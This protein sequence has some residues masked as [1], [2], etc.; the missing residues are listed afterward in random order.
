[1]RSIIHIPH[2]N[3]KEKSKYAGMISSP[4]NAFRNFRG[5]KERYCPHSLVVMASSSVYN[6]FSGNGYLLVLFGFTMVKMINCFTDGT[7][8]E[9]TLTA[10]SGRSFKGFM[11]EAR[12]Y[13][14]DGFIFY[15]HHYTDNKLHSVKHHKSK[16]YR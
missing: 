2:E 1:M 16:F 9:M 14:H 3:G 12:Q 8:L 10:D 6:M 11:L 4:L 7:M 5:R 13:F 15:T